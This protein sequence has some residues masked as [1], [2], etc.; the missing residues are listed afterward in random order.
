MVPIKAPPYYT[1][2]IWP[3]VSNTQGGPVHD[4]TY[5]VLNP[6][7]EAIPRLFEAGEC[8]GIWG[9]L[10]AGGAN[11]TE[12]FVGGR[13]ALDRR[14]VTIAVLCHAKNF[15]APQAARLHPTKPYFCFAPCVDGEFQV[16]AE[17]P[18]HQRQALVEPGLFLGR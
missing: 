7:G 4:G 18:R 9:W 16:D 10:Y 11:L 13:I 14:D 5:R 8:G 2:E 3:V 12:C 17:H 15:R 1:G 6:F